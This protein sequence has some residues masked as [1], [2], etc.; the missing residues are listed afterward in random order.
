MSKEEVSR[1]MKRYIHFHSKYQE[2]TRI[3]QKHKQLQDQLKSVFDDLKIEQHTI[4][5]DGYDAT[6]HFKPIMSTRIDTS[7]MPTALKQQYTRKVLT[8]REQ[9]TVRSKPA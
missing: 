9:L 6:L 1:L 5:E 7:A 4:H 2:A 3:I 8:R